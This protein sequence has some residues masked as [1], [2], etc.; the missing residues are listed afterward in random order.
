M[1]MED[2]LAVA[3][4]RASIHVVAQSPCMLSLQLRK[5]QMLCWKLL[6]YMVEAD[7]WAITLRLSGPAV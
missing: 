5:A 2:S 3:L 7:A 6:L 4:C 1:Q